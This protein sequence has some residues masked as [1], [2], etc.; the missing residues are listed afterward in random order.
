MEKLLEQWQAASGNL[1][2]AQHAYAEAQENYERAMAFYTA[3]RA[4]LL[5]TAADAGAKG[6]Q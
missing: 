3:K 2:R 4:E 6:A 1:L 5:P